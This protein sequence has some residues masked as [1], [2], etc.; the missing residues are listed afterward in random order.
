MFKQF[1]STIFI[2]SLLFFLQNI[3]FNINARENKSL[4]QKEPERIFSITNEVT[5]SMINIGNWGYWFQSNGLSAREPYSGNSGAFYPRGLVGAIWRE[6]LVWGGIVDDPNES[7]PKIRVGGN[8]YITGTQPGWFNGDP[9]DSRA[10]IY[11]IRRDWAELQREDLVREAV[12]LYNISE[13]AVMEFHLDEII[14]NYKEDWKNWPVDLGA[15]YYDVDSNGLYNPVL[16]ENGMPDPEQGDY[17]G[18]A[19]ADQVMWFVFN[20]QDEQL[21]KNLYGSP[22][23]GLEIQVT[24][25]AYNQPTSLLGQVIYKKYKII[26]YSGFTIDSMYVSQ[27]S[28]P[29]IGDY[30][31][32]LNGCDPSLNLAFAYNGY[33]TDGWYSEFGLNPAAVGYT[34]LQGPVV[35]STG[36]TAIFNSGKLADFKNLPMT[37][38]GYFTSGAQW[39]DPKRGSY[40][41]T[42]QWYNLLKGYLPTTNIDDPTW[43]T[44]TTGSSAGQPTKF[45]MDGDPV[46]GYG[47]IDGIKYLPSDRRMALNSGPF[48]MENGDVQEVV[49]G[50]VGGLGS[51]NIQ[52]VRELKSNVSYVIDNYSKPVSFPK[53]SYS[54]DYPNATTTKLTVQVDLNNFEDV[55]SC[56]LNFEPITGT[57]GPIYFDLFDDGLNDDQLAGDR[58]WGVSRLI[59]NKKF[60][61]KAHLEINKSSSSETF[62]NALYNLKLR[63]APELINWRI[64]WENGKQDLNINNDET[65]MVQFDIYNPD[66]RN[67]MDS[68]IINNFNSP[69]GQQTVKYKGTIMSV[70][71]VLHGSLFFELY[72]NTN[73]DSLDVNYNINFDGHQVWMHTKFPVISWS[74]NPIWGD[75]LNVSSVKGVASNIF[76]IVA[77]PDLLNGHEYLITF[78]EDSLNDELTWNLKDITQSELLLTNAVISGDK[79][80]QHPVIDGI[81]FKVV[82]VPELVTSFECVSNANGPLAPYQGA[83]DPRLGYPVPASPDQNQQV[84]D[85]VWLISAGLS[86]YETD[87]DAFMNSVFAFAGGAFNPEG[88]GIK[89]LIPRD[90][91]IR[92]TETGGK[93]VL[94]FTTRQIIDV[95]FELWDIGDVDDVSDDYQLIPYVYDIDNNGIFNLMYDATDPNSPSGWADH[96]NDTGLNDPYTDGIYW[97]HP[98]NNTPFT[99][100]YDKFMAALEA[101]PDNAPYVLASPGEYSGD[102]DVW[103]GMR[104]IVFINMNGGDVTT[105]NSFN[106]YNQALPEVGTTF[107]LVTAKPNYDGDELIVYST[108]SIRNKDSKKPVNFYLDQNYPNPFNPYT[109]IRFGL[110]A[111]TKVDISIYNVLG[112]KVK[113]LMNKEMLGGNHEITWDGKNDRGIRLSSGLYFYKLKTANYSITRKMIILN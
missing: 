89:H 12:E 79:Y 74:P 99:E 3:P 103:S 93:A 8:T 26:N 63:P 36:D 82:P 37:S 42:L 48:R 77:D 14:N 20:D 49:I 53:I 21:V 78:R 64:I 110:P 51:S 104:R 86:G 97:M 102:L 34:L 67:G 43:F 50:I 59:D 13:S 11:R 72:P 24:I 100:G 73:E 95:P 112:R 96:Q 107:R 27:W 101:N 44:V 66:G 10:R 75:T 6:G 16:D 81:I 39:S 85:G 76:P 84:G 57:E 4:K 28:D 38:F 60:P 87:F 98:V 65:V 35:P 40:E 32:D 56:Q 18:I 69:G 19:N 17:P 94:Y 9:G 71:T 113:T 25:W 45:P 46:S 80:F 105:A 54:F 41:G 7:K 1:K 58:I 30:G 92:F 33:S 91:E 90:Y 70:G 29:D 31:D 2:V 88:P 106:D 47:D 15:P 111:Q 61:Y 62:L 5:Q 108:T 109:K 68:V 52:S 23:I 22:S 83:A 55:Q